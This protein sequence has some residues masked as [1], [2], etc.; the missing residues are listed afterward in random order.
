MVPSLEPRKSEFY[1]RQDT[2]VG[3]DRLK[4]AF[5]MVVRPVAADDPGH[6]VRKDRGE[7]DALRRHACQYESAG[8]FFAQ[9]DR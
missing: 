1:Y 2:I 4:V 7:R 9:K 5:V 8:P 6:C 3:E